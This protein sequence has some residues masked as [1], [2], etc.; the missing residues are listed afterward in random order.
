MTLDRPGTRNA[1]SMDMWLAI[2]DGFRELSS[3]DVRVIVL[4]GANGDFSSGADIV[5]SEGRLGLGGQQAQRHAA[6]SAESV[7][8]VHDC[9]IPVIAKVDGYAVGAGVR[10]GAGGR[11][12]VVLRPGQVL[13]RVR[14]A[15]AQPRLR[16]VVVPRPAHRAAQGQGDRLHRRDDRRRARRSPRVRQRGRA[17]R[18]ARRRRRRDGPAHRR[19]PA[20][21]PVDDEAHA[22]QRV[23]QLAGARARDRG[24]RPERQPRAPATWWRR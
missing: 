18:R 17:G 1:C 6:R 8:A 16:L 20:D 19:R 3:S 24:H 9:P 5:K 12:A 23:A 13:G 10:P 7:I 15:R 14:Q 11:P 22:R 2:R 4:T 21:R